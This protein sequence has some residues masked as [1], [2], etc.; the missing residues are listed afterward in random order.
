MGRKRADVRPTASN[1][2]VESCLAGIDVADDELASLQGTYMADCKGPRATIR[3]IRGGLREAGFNM[4]AFAEIL[5]NH[6]EERKRQKRIAAMENDDVFAYEDM[7]KGLGEFADTP[8]GS[9]ALDRV[10]PAAQEGALDG[11]RP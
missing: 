11:L 5:R 9:A 10:R 8:L 1:I 7:R 6:R 3:E 4:K 2:T